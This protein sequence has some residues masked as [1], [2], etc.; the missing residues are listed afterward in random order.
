MAR[1]EQDA[2]MI[3]NDDDDD[4]DDFMGKYPNSKERKCL[5]RPDTASALRSCYYDSL[6]SEPQLIRLRDGILLFPYYTG[7]TMSAG[8]LD[9]E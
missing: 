8:S 7:S 6:E 9:M 4:N 5:S 1:Y 3:T 2:Y